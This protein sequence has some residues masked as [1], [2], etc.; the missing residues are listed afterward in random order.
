MKEKTNCIWNLNRNCNFNCSYCYVKNESEKKGHGVDIDIP[1]FKSNKINWGNITLCGGEPFIY[2]NFVDLCKGFT[3]FTDI[4]INTNCS[5]SNIYD[6]ADVINPNKVRELFCSLHIG[7]RKKNTYDELINKIHYLKSKGF[8]ICLT[9]VMHPKL[10]SEYKKTYKQFEEE[11]IL[12]VPRPMKGVWHLKEYPVAYKPFLK[13]EILS[14]TEKSIKQ[15]SV[16]DANNFYSTTFGKVDWYNQLCGAGSK[17]II[18][19][20]DGGVYTCF[21]M[22]KYL[23][24]LYKGDIKL[25][26]SKLLCKAKQC[27]CEQEGRNNHGV[28]GFIHMRQDFKNIAK[29]TIRDVLFKIGRKSKWE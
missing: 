5:T 22:K 26:D 24:N 6:F 25:L 29:E 23:G 11:G 27:T 15:K 18:I 7:E 28:D 12:I 9:Q 20:Y 1:A 17:S 16:Y 21:G 10:F 14:Y 19:R 3:E 4:T 13:R 2:P 8:N